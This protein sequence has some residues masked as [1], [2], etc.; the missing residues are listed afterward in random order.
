MYSLLWQLGLASL[1]NVTDRID[2]ER[3]WEERFTDIS[4][5]TRQTYSPV[6]SFNSHSI[7]MIQDNFAVRINYMYPSDLDKWAQAHM[8]TNGILRSKHAHFYIGSLPL[9]L[10][11]QRLE[12]NM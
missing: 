5:V 9:L 2:M 6:L 12:T 4:H 7:C 10:P 11:H 1:E 3:Q 8:V